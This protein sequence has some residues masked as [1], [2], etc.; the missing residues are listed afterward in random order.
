MISP[1]NKLKT[2]VMQEKAVFIGMDISKATLYICV[3]QE[4]KRSHYVIN[5]EVAAIQRFFTEVT[6]PTNSYIGIENTGRY[7]WSL[8]TAMSQLNLPIYVLAP[9]M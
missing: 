6:L 9:C 3:L 8:Y 1:I 7:N 4:D 2:K 5:N